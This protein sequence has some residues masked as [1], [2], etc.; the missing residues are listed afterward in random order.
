MSDETEEL[1]F[2]DILDQSSIGGESLADV[3]RYLLSYYDGLADDDEGEIDITKLTIDTESIKS[4]AYLKN[5][6][7]G[8]EESAHTMEEF[9]NDSPPQPFALDSLQTGQFLLLNRIQ[10]FPGLSIPYFTTSQ[11]EVDLLLQYLQNAPSLPILCVVGGDLDSFDMNIRL[12]CAVHV[13]YGALQRGE[14]GVRL[15]VV[16]VCNQP[17]EAVRIT[18]NLDRVVSGSVR[19]TGSAELVTNALPCCAV[20]ETTRTGNRPRSLLSRTAVELQEILAAASLLRVVDPGDI[21]EDSSQ[22]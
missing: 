12:G 14:S 13:E 1:G 18:H 4:H 17:C 21:S 3:V 10:P 19:V 5:M 15:G 9:F 6:V 7:C 11:D 16:M 2:A 22:L 20:R 8:G